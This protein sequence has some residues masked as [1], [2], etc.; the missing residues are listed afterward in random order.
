MDW[1]SANQ[2]LAFY[3][4]FVWYTINEDLIEKYRRSVEE[5]VIDSLTYSRILVVFNMYMNL[6][7]GFVNTL[8]DCLLCRVS[9]MRQMMLTQSGEPGRVICW[10]SFSH[11]HAIYGSHRNFLCFTGFVYY[12]LLTLF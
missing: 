6:S 2:I 7:L 8:V 9:C 12:L 10:T 11:Q 4:Y 5:M 3:P 1:L